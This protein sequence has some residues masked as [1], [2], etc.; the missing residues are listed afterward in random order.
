MAYHSILGADSSMNSL[1]LSTTSFGSL[2]HLRKFHLGTDIAYSV[3]GKILIFLQIKKINCTVKSRN[4]FKGIE[5]HV[6]FLLEMYPGKYFHSVTVVIFSF[7]FKLPKV[8]DVY[9]YRI[10]TV[11]NAFIRKTLSI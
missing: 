5:T 4:L 11:K 8:S 1:S 3:R 6:L 7:I 9:V 2:I 10:E